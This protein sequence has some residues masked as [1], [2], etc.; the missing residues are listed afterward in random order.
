MPVFSESCGDETP[1]GAYST[2]ELFVSQQGRIFLFATASKPALGPTQPHNIQWLPGFF[3]GGK[4]A[5]HE[6][7][8]SPPSSAEI[9]NA[10]SYTYT[11]PY[12]CM[13]W[14]LIKHPAEDNIKM[15]LKK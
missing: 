8:H 7:N 4:A 9:K 1:H 13:A 11:A 2:S 3:F 10:W 14:C 6:T 15:I 5:G 12:V